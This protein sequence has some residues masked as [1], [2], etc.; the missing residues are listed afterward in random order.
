MAED[1]IDSVIDL[2]A[3]DAEFQKLDGKL[4]QTLAK[5]K[6]FST[7]K[8]SFN[9]AG[10][11]GGLNDAQK[12]LAKGQTELT[13]AMKEYNKIVDGIAVKQAKLNAMTSEAA[14]ELERLKLQEQQANQARKDSIRLDEAKE[15]SINQLR[16]QLRQAQLAYDALSKAERDSSRGTSLLANIK[17]L[18]AE[19]KKLEGT[20]GRF[21][22][23]VGNYTGALADSF[24]S[25]RR[26]IARLQVAQ[27]DLNDR[28]D[29][30][31][32]A[33][34]T[35]SI[36]NLD[37]V[38]KVSFDNTKSY[39]QQ[40]KSLEREYVNLATSGEQS[41][42][43]LRDFKNAVGEAKDSANDLRE[44]IKLAASDT[45]QLDVLIGA[46][47]AIAGGFA[48]AEGA[49][50]VF[51]D[52][53]EDLQKTLVKLN[54][55]MAIL[56]G[57]QAIQNELKK[58]D[59]IVTGIQIGL[60]KAYAFAVGTSTGAMKAFR[61][62][63]AATGVG[64]LVIGVGALISKLSG[65]GSTA[66]ATA[67]DLNE[68]K[69]ALEDL[70]FVND[71][72]VND[73]QRQNN[74]LISSMK[75]R[76]ASEQ[77]ISN[78]NIEGL[79]REKAEMDKL[80]DATLQELQTSQLTSV[81]KVKGYEDAVG[82]LRLQKAI[83]SDIEE[84]E[85]KSNKR[86]EQDIKLT[87][88]KI[89]A[90]QAYVDAYDKAADKQNEIDVQTNERTADNLKRQQEQAK[91]ALE[92]RNR[93]LERNREAQFGI[94]QELL[95]RQI[96]FNDAI[97]QND[98]E[99]LFRRLKAF[100]DFVTAKQR[101]ITLEENFEKSKVGATALE[102][103]LA[104]EKAIS[105]RLQLEREAS[106]AR[107]NIIRNEARIIEAIN[108][109]RTA[110]YEK[111]L[112][113]SEEA[114]TKENL[115]AEKLR[116]ELLRDN[117]RAYNAGIRS[118]EDY[119]KTREDIERDYELT[120]LNNSLAHYERLL[121]ANKA[122]GAATIEQEA[123]V[124]AIRKRL[125]ELQPGPTESATEKSRRELEEFLVEAQTRF[126]QFAEFTSGLS[127]AIADREKNRI[128]KQLDDIERIKKREIELIQASGDSE[129]RK[130][131]RIKV[132]EAKAAA[133]REA[134]EKKKRDADYRAA[135]YEKALTI[136]QIIL[137]NVL[138][139]VKAIPKGPAAVI[140]AIILGA[141]Q[142]AVAVATPVPRFAKGTKNAPRGLG[143]WGEE[144]QE[145]MVDRHGKLRL[146]PKGPT[147]INLAGGEQII[148]A[149]NTRR[150]LRSVG[151]EHELDGRGGT[152]S[153]D[154]RELIGLTG[155]AVHELRKLN[156]RPV[157]NQYVE[158]GIE[159]TE[160]FDKT[161]RH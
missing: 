30:E 59:N 79:K 25:V 60:Q 45:R 29:T 80:R 113:A 43:F 112:T 27:K 16:V 33:R 51:G 84:D 110:N 95:Q 42:Q 151:M 6:E 117:Q 157:L 55:V 23:N 14:T 90:L 153:I 86:K 133:D 139:V 77:E 47:Q 138:N 56:N 78:A 120:T 156:G 92:D 108:N 104:E 36:E 96:A 143:I 127:Q 94:D 11:L 69:I 98:T 91:K 54:G 141:T 122:F 3:I 53:N 115:Q 7:L 26:E 154:Q 121:K 48:I 65:L 44:S 124:A 82:L 159:T 34:V 88:G 63:L 125:A 132:I 21:Q 9:Q 99:T 114:L 148:P 4:D 136:T 87:K 22:R 61:I 10:D 160:T 128:Q 93:L 119:T 85:N 76:G 49:A 146:S 24:E 57:L 105:K 64:L 83:L 75:A 81:E 41:E 150:I 142:L 8:I 118:L 68:L 70:K 39:T 13:L 149:D 62:A 52:E 152:L 97:Q 103:Q 129:E 74:L 106:E 135:V 73:I 15:G 144:G 66:K 40:V 100:D 140:E 19:L 147:L 28:G 130:A 35:R 134:L 126:G 38:M 71:R 18:D 161:F 46:G 17:T 37:R 1:R 2:Q 72:A 32:A 137:S 145:M 116:D 20:T 107:I 50:A 102:K 158:R 67:V 123:A 101:L 131:A 155:M 111:Q 58:K 89:D 5:L 12:K 31:G 109:Q